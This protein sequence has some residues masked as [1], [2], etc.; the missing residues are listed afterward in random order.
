M[1]TGDKIIVSNNQIEMAGF[2]E[3]NIEI[4]LNIDLNDGYFLNII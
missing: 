1:S 4:N 2:K 3:R